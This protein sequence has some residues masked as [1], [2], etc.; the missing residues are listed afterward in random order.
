MTALNRRLISFT[1]SLN[2]VSSLTSNDVDIWP[3]NDIRSFIRSCTVGSSS[4]IACNIIPKIW[5]S[6]AADKDIIITER[7]LTGNS[8]VNMWTMTNI[9]RLHEQD[10]WQPEPQ[11]LLTHFTLKSLWC[12]LVCLLTYLA[13]QIKLHSATSQVAITLIKWVDTHL[14]ASRSNRVSQH[15]KGWTSLDFNETRDDEMAVASAGPHTNHLHLS[16]NR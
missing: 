9:P 11:H 6:A 8:C 15:Q 5:R 4:N 14:M 1:V 2:V 16:S 13:T 3:A 10:R 12:L 7:T